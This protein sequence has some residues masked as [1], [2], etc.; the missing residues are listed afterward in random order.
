MFVRPFHARPPQP[1]DQINMQRI[2]VTIAISVAT[3]LFTL[4]GVLWGL[5]RYPVPLSTKSL[6]D[7]TVQHDKL[8]LFRGI[9]ERE[10]TGKG[11]LSVRHQEYYLTTPEQ[12]C[13]T[14]YFYGIRASRVQVQTIPYDGVEQL[15]VYKP[16][17][18]VLLASAT[19][20]RPTNGSEMQKQYFDAAGTII[21]EEAYKAILSG[22]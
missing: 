6:T 21:P 15:K 19:I 7:G 3:T 12:T 18:D 4:S 1:S 9:L 8:W 10:V 20:L 17:A 22:H 14:T 13:V 2:L 16:E 5:C 11:G